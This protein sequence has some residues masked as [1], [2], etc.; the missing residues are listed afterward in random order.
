MLI[1]NT[2]DAV[3]Y[4]LYGGKELFSSLIDPGMSRDLSPCGSAG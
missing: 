3:L 2:A 4:L 1:G